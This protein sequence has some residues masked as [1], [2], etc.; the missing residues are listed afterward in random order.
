MIRRNIILASGPGSDVDSLLHAR[1]ARAAREVCLNARKACC[2]T[3]QHKIAV[4]R[5]HLE[6]CLGDMR[7]GHSL[8]D[9]GC[10]CSGVYYDV[11]TLKEVDVLSR[12]GPCPLSRNEARV[13]PEERVKIVD[14]AF[15]GVSASSAS[16]VDSAH[17]HCAVCGVACILPFITPCG[18]LICIGC[19]D[20][21]PVKRGDACESQACECKVWGCG[22]L[23]SF[24][25]FAAFQPSYE[26]GDV[27]WSSNFTEKVG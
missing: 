11:K 27:S 24:G 7:R 16:I 8:Q 10:R 1:N 6:E 13:V 19:L 9:E 14:R 5:R 20:L 26:H 23:W 12:L 4:V 17:A 22:A 15:I 18:H 25:R 3:G 2:V 21:T